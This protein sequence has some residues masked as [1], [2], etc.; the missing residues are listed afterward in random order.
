M[1]VSQKLERHLDWAVKIRRNAAIQMTSY[2][3]RT[4][5]HYNK[6]ARPRSFK[7][8]TLV[9]IRIFENTA[10]RGVGKFQANWED[11]YVVTKAEDSM[12]YHFQTLDGVPL[13]RRWNMSNLKQYYQ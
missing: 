13:L 4:I 10:N 7:I 8:E 9:L 1:N 11:P 2:H 3:Q 5:A 6:K 12:A